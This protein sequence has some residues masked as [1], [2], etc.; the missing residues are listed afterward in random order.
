MRAR[1]DWADLK[2]K[3]HGHIAHVVPFGQ[4]YALCGGAP[5]G[6]HDGWYGS[7]SMDEIEKAESLPLCGKCTALVDD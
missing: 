6:L 4:D 1:S 3:K 5:V 7:G 2:Y